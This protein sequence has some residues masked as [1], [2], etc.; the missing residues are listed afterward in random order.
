MRRRRL[1]ARRLR[2][3]AS[4]GAATLALSWQKP[5]DAALD[6]VAAV[7]ALARRGS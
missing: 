6:L 2:P 5:A 3:D 1:A 4:S 7:R